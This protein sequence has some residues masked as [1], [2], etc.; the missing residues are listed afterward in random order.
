M[1]GLR[2]WTMKIALW[3][4]GQIILA[5]SYARAEGVSAK[6]TLEVDGRSI[7]DGKC[8]VEHSAIDDGAGDFS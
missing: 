1:G 7:W 5:S 8:C 3:V 4:I 6:C 2:G